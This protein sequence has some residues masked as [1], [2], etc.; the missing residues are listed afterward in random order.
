MSLSNDQIKELLKPIDP[1]RVGKDGKGFSHVAAWDV[2][3]RMNQ[4][5]GFGEWSSTVDQMEFVAERET[6]TRQGKDAWNV[7]YRAQCTVMVNGAVYTEWAAGDATNPLLFEAHDQAIKTAESQA[8]KRCAMNL[9]DQFGLSLY[10]DGSVKAT[11]GEVVTFEHADS[12]N[13]GAWLESFEGAESVEQVMETA[14][15]IKQADIS[16]QDRNT[17]L[18]GYKAA[19]KRLGVG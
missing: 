12:V 1:A 2:R 10:N 19:T 16:A 3:R 8:F 15:H 14:L 6:K 9:G 17:L 13:V 18:A 4:I 11:V 5:F 7:I